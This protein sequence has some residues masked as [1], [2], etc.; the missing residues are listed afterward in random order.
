MEEIEMDKHIMIIDD[1][2]TIRISVEIALKGIGMP[3]EQAENGIDALEKIKKI[4]EQ[5]GDIA[6]CICDVNMPQM[7]GISFV[8]EFK[9][10][11]KFTPIIILTTESGEEKIQIGKD[12]GVSGWLVKP[13]Q[14]ADLIKIVERF[15]K[16]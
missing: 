14:P 10:S 12:A 9:K 16:K 13:F 5:G 3:V 1:S 11:D 15:I 7:D 2:P 4:K 8:K 6:L